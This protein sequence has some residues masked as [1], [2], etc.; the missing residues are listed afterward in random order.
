[1][2]AAELSRTYRRRS[3]TIALEC[4]WRAILSP[5]Y[6][7]CRR[8]LVCVAGSRMTNRSSPRELATSRG[9]LKRTSG[10]RKGRMTPQLQIAVN[11]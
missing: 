9:G 6:L 11:I 1:M 3:P 7:V 5:A 10:L 8:P 2:Q 4:L